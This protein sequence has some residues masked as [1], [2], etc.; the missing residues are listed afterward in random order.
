MAQANKDPAY[1]GKSIDQIPRP[2]SLSRTQIFIWTLIIAGCYLYLQFCRACNICTNPID[3][4]S[5]AL[6]LMGISAGTATAGAMI[7]SSQ[8]GNDRHQNEPSSGFIKDILSDDNGISIHRFQN[9]LWTFICIGI[10]VYKT[11]HCAQC[12]LPDLDSTLIGLTGISSATY[13]LMKVRE[14]AGSSAPKVG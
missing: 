10:Y 12:A 13:A 14:N 8:D 6:L 7:D 3:I 1:V 2:F 5:T 4:N 9:V 11:W